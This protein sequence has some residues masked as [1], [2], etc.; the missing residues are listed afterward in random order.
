MKVLRLGACV[1]AMALAG[2]ANAG[3][4]AYASAEQPT[5]DGEQT[6]GG[7]ELVRIFVMGDQLTKWCRAYQRL[8]AGGKKAASLQLV[9]DAAMCQGE[10]E[11]ASDADQING[12]NKDRGLPT[13]CEPKET[14][15][16]DMVMVAAKYL[17]A[18]PEK[19]T[20]AGYALI[21][22]AWAEAWPCK[23]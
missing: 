13:H 15:G 18:H 4:S 20:L 23:N 1:V 6:T 17:E 2:E 11:M 8:V 9:Y 22:M 12:N 7:G 5:G 19:R 21:R 16:G 10:V 3:N 14:N